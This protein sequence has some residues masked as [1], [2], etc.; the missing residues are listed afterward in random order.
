[1]NLHQK[2]YRTASKYRVMRLGLFCL[3]FV[4]M[5]LSHLRHSYVSY[6]P[7]ETKI[8][9]IPNVMVQLT[10]TLQFQLSVLL[11]FVNPKDLQHIFGYNSI[12]KK[13]FSKHH[14]KYFIET[15]F[16]M[17][18]QDF[19]FQGPTSQTVFYL[20]LHILLY[21]LHKIIKCCGPNINFIKNGVF[22]FELIFEFDFNRTNKNLK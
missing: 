5:S 4:S 13:S 22:S 15:I 19:H 20:I 11:G 21:N 6:Y 8:D 9:Q 1:M 14:K 17:L 3:G 10:M 7:T 18:F 12:Q 2:A 16:L